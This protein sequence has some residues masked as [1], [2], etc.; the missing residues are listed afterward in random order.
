MGVLS[1]C[2]TRTKY[3]NFFFSTYNLHVGKK[4]GDIWKRIILL[5]LM[6]QQIHMKMLELGVVQGWSLGI[7]QA[8]AVVQLSDPPWL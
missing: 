7:A 5:L 8:G 6:T 3:L 4:I 2:E 1:C